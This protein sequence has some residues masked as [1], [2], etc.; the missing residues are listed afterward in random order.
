M[1]LRSFEKRPRAN[2][3]E[4]N[5]ESIQKTEFAVITNKLNPAVQS[6]WNKY[7]YKTTTQL[8]HNSFPLISY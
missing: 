4:S 5:Y 7:L 6:R 2:K 3:Y 1:V 8:S